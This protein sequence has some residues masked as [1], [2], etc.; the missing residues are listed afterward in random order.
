M[1][2]QF[3]HLITIA[4]I[5]NCWPQ[6]SITH[7]TE[8]LN[9][10]SSFVCFSICSWWKLSK[11]HSLIVSMVWIN[12]NWYFYHEYHH[13]NY[14]FNISLTIISDYITKRTFDKMTNNFVESCQ[15]TMAIVAQQLCQK[16]YFAS[17]QSIWSVIS[18][19]LHRINNINHIET[20]NILNR[21]WS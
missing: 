19:N 10:L 21:F 2:L 3:W 1:W 14:K 15:L 8:P 5:I 18:F 16:Y 20:V 11:I 6:H 17:M 9:D 4:L 12:L 7:W 13:Q